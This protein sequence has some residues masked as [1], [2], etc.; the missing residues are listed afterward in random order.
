MQ[1]D[2][3]SATRLSSLAHNTAAHCGIVAVVGSLRVR[4]L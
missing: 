1:M 4:D 3:M 2:P